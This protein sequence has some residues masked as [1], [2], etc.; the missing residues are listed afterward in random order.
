MGGNGRTLRK[1]TWHI[2]DQ[3]L[4]CLTYGQCRAQT[5]TKN[6][7]KINWFTIITQCSGET[8]H[9]VLDISGNFRSHTYHD[10]SHKEV[11]IAPV[12]AFVDREYIRGFF[13]PREMVINITKGEQDLNSRIKFS[14]PSQ[15]CGSELGKNKATK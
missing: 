10:C 3:N 5:H 12:V 14:W 2:S 9:L 11:I 6:I 15:I 4:G 13:E 7:A 1:T 8:V